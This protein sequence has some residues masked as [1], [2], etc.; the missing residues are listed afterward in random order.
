MKKCP[1]CA[2]EIQDEAIVCKH[3]GRDLRKPIEPVESVKAPEPIKPVTSQASTANVAARW[4]LVLT[5][6]GALGFIVDYRGNSVELVGTLTVGSIASFIFWWVVCSA[7]VW[8]W[9][10]FGAIKIVLFTV[11][12]MIVFGVV[13]VV[14]FMAGQN[15]LNTPAAKSTPR[16]TLIPTSAQSGFDFSATCYQW[17]EINK[18]MI[19]EKHCVYGD[20]VSIEQSEGIATRL[21]FS[22]EPNSFVLLSPTYSYFDVVHTGDC[23]QVIDTVLAFGD[24]L[25]MNIGDTIYNCSQ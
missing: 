8:A 22:R 4:A 24:L 21:E 2:E 16:P 5:G 6:L 20:V 9:R 25:Y 13:V 11:V 14:M 17:H 18:S 23:V 7:F 3:C 12:I 1:Y 10:T 19:G 15:Y